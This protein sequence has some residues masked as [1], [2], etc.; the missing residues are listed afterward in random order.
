M[1]QLWAKLQ[2]HAARLRDLRALKAQLVRLCQLPVRREHL[3]PAA[4]L[5]LLFVAVI[6][7]AVSTRK[8]SQ[9]SQATAIAVV[10]AAA[11]TTAMAPAADRQRPG[12]CPLSL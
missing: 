6:V 9:E 10:P 2:A 8:Q 5:V 12:Q 4:A 11:T 3:F 1:Q 7:A